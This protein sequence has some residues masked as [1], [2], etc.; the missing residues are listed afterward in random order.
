MHDDGLYTEGRSLFARRIDPPDL[1]SGVTNDGKIALAR[2]ILIE[3]LRDILHGFLAFQSSA[4]SDLVSVVG[5][6]RF[7][8]IQTEDPGQQNV[9]SE[10]RIGIERK[11][12]RIQGNIVGSKHGDTLGIDPGNAFQTPAPAQPVMDKDKVGIRIRGV[13]E[14]SGTGVDAEHSFRHL[15]GAFELEA[16]VGGI[17]GK[18]LQ[19]QDFIK[20][21]GHFVDRRHFHFLLSEIVS[22]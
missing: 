13:H 21:S 20:I 1:P 6:E 3:E 11:M 15:S 17:G 10:F 8:F 12:R 5:S 19:I 2:Q 14:E 9:V 18:G 16:V 22:A 7:D 4:E